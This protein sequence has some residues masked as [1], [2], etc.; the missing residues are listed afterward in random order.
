MSF[1][2]KVSYHPYLLVAFYLRCL[3]IDIEERIP[4]STRHDWSHKDM[5]SLYGYEWYLQN[6]QLF[7]TLQQVSVSNRLLQINRALLRVIAL[8][9]FMGHHAHRIKDNVQ[10][11]NGVIL[12]NIRKISDSIGLKTA[13]KSLQ[14]SYS[15]YLKMR[16]D[17]C[18]S[19]SILS[20]C[21]IKHPTQLLIREISAIKEYCSDVRFMHWP[22]S[23][24]YH[25]I[26]RDAAAG[27]TSVPFINMYPCS[28]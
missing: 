1:R 12:D 28:I 7:Q 19:I 22:L 8:K 24:V 23:S 14:L 27:F 13:L 6:Q 18:C 5:A 17:N 21:R 2:P 11:I 3:P 4:K 9:R 20:L 10:G 25:Q 16:I 15:Q 26:R